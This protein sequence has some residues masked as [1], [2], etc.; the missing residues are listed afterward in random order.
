MRSR[1]FRSGWSIEVD[2][3]LQITE[4]TDLLVDCLQ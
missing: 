4:E 3:T 2:I 1:R